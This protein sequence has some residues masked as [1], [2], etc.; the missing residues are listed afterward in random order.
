[1]WRSVI[2]AFAIFL[3]TAAPSLGHQMPAGGSGHAGHFAAFDDT[4]VAFAAAD[5]S[6][7][8]P[9]ACTHMITPHCLGAIDLADTQP[10][11][12]AEYSGRWQFHIQNLR[13]QGIP[14]AADTPPPRS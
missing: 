12:P 13:L 6:D 11:L 8:M 4:V 14:P 9:A 1:M 2:F 10:Y 7:C 5:P 3:L